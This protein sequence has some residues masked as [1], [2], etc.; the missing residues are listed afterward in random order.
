M[1]ISPVN[2]ALI[3]LQG[4][5]R[6]I[7]LHASFY[8]SLAGE[9]TGSTIRFLTFFYSL[10]VLQNAVWSASGFRNWHIKPIA[11]WVGLEPITSAL[12][13]RRSTIELPINIFNIKSRGR[14]VRFLVYVRRS[15]KKCISI[16]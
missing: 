1:T 15:R 11:D 6:V 4:F 10:R 16:S 12:T 13:G 8:V 5:L 7:I 3:H 2:A 14:G 9:G